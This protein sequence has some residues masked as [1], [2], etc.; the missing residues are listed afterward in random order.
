MWKCLGLPKS[1]SDGECPGNS[2]VHDVKLKFHLDGDPFMLFQ[3]SVFY[4]AV[5]DI[6]E[7]VSSFLFSFV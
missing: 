7:A 6:L 3:K 1:D 2:A 5:T 4:I